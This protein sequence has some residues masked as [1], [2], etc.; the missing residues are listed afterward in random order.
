M[1]L[2]TSF[3]D[4]SFIR[5][6]LALDIW[7]SMDTSHIKIKTYSAV[8]YLNGKY[9]GLYTACEMVNANLMEE[10]EPDRDGNLYKGRSHVANFFLKDNP[11]LGFEKEEGYPVNGDAGAYA[12]MDE[13]VNFIS[14]TEPDDFI[15]TIDSIL[16]QREYEDWWMYVLF[17]TASDSCEKNAYHHHDPGNGV[18]RYI[19]WDFN[20][21]FGQNYLTYRVPWS[22]LPNYLNLNNIFK[23][24]MELDAIRIPIRARFFD[25][26][27]PGNALDID[28]ILLKI[29]EYY[30]EIHDAAV[31]SEEKWREKYRN[32]SPWK[33]RTDFT[34]FKEE[35]QYIKNWLTEHHSLLLDEYNR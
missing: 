10:H 12:D 25:L 4:N 16:N 5:N 11:H 32:S 26:L 13:L 17:M 7:N 29:D 35:I 9:W 21:S 31:K 27:S 23:R 3:N 2:I 8:V 24:F 22:F 18:W 1:I 19:P 20:S 28:R 6:R 14:T 30:E 15:A 34:T 33:S